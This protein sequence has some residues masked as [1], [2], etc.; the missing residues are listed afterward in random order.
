MGLGL[1]L[2]GRKN[3]LHRRRRN[4]KPCGES[5]ALSLSLALTPPLVYTVFPDDT[6][7]E[8]GREPPIRTVDLGWKYL[9]LGRARALSPGVDNNR[10]KA[11]C[12]L[13][14]LLA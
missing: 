13:R 6:R 12:K 11:H 8:S 7:Q 3:A 5:P 1:V 14:T 4:V 9:P 2:V 10:A